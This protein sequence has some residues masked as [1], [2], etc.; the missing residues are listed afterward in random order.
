[1]KNILSIFVTDLRRLA[2][3]WIALVVAVGI[4]VIPSLYAWFNIAANWDPYSN[5]QGIRVAVASQDEGTTLEGT[6]LN[7]GRMIVEKLA[8]NRQIGWE[9][10]DNAD[11]AMEGVKSGEYYA[12]ILIP[13]DF[14]EKSPAFSQATFVVPPLSTMSTKR[15]TPLLPKSPTRGWAWYSRRSTRPLLL[16]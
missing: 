1:M 8:T 2:T 6:E 7:I 15:K 10:M 4:I 11:E 14:S 12:T 3:N 16:P 9:I 13:A 5:T